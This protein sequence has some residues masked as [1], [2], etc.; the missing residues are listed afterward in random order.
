M[1][2]FKL[3]SAV[4]LIVIFLGLVFLGGLL[5]GRFVQTNEARKGNKQTWHKVI[6]H[7]ESE[8][9]K[10]LSEPYPMKVVRSLRFFDNV[11]VSDINT[12]PCGIVKSL[13]GGK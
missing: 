4:A 5:A 10:G 8:S 7:I 2:N 1:R 13:G 12:A 6:C 3:L 9:V 11:L